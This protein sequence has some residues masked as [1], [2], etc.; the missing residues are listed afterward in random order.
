MSGDGG[1]EF[2]RLGRG[3]RLETVEDRRELDVGRLWTLVGVVARTLCVS[4]GKR[5]ALLE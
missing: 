4:V 5:G 3:T 1:V 2:G